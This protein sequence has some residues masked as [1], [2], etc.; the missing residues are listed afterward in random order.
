MRAK[1]NEK[2]GNSN[3]KQNCIGQ[4]ALSFLVVD[5]DVDT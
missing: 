3:G 2:G 5:V 4:N 1:V